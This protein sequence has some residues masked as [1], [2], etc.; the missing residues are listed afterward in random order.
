MALEA[1]EVREKELL[2][3]LN[4]ERTQRAKEK[5][6]AEMVREALAESNASFEDEIKALKTSGRLAI[7]EMETAASRRDAALDAK[8][9]HLQ[10]E[11]ESAT[12]AHAEVEAAR[13]ATAMG[14]SLRIAQLEIRSMAAEAEE[15]RAQVDQMREQVLEGH[16]HMHVHMRCACAFAG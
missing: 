2:K 12:V 15:L 4:E 7:A 10:A 8:L 9:E 6:A 11:V 5:R 1:A 16:V 13:E 14:R 3:A